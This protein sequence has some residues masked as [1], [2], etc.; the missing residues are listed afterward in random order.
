LGRWRLLEH[1][2]WNHANSSSSTNTFNTAN[3]T[4]GSGQNT[5][6]VNNSTITTA[7][8]DGGTPAPTPT[9][10]AKN[11]TITTLNKTNFT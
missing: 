1:G 4:M 3:V 9:C 2:W 11:V 7:N 10:R 8:F 5:L 6:K